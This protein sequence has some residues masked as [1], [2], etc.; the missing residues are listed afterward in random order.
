MN[1]SEVLT[2]IANEGGSPVP[3]LT[4]Q[5]ALTAATC[6]AILATIAPAIAVSFAQTYVPN[7][8]ST[9]HDCSGGFSPVL[10]VPAAAGL[11]SSTPHDG[12]RYYHC[13]REA[14]AP[15]AS[16][17]VRPIRAFRSRNGVDAA[18]DSD[19][20]DGAA[21]RRRIVGEDRARVSWRTRRR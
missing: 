9:S 11:P 13:L 17:Q 3:C 20:V 2:P 1:L 18:A 5:P 12:P 7:A 10:Q 8:R 16:P 14:T 6:A 4:E 15:V 19:D 21:D